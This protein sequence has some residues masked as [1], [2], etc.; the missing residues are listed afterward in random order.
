MRV[1]LFV[2]KSDVV[3]NL[4]LTYK[5]W[6]WLPQHCWCQSEAKARQELMAGPALSPAHP[7]GNT[8]KNF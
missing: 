5:A 1:I 2:K 7:G 3:G 6:Q 8:A 4:N